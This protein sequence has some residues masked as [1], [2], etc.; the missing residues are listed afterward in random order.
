MKKRY[1]SLDILRGLTVALMIVVN[2]PG[3]WGK[4]FPP[5]R[6]AEWDGCTPTDLVFPFFLF[7]VGTSMAFA[8]AKYD[9]LSRE[10]LTKIF[11]RGIGIFLVGLGLHAFPFYPTWQDPDLTLWQNYLEWFREFRTFGVLQ[12]IALCYVVASVLALW[13]RIP[14]KILA[15]IAVLSVL[16][17]G[18][19]LV[20]AGPEGAF[21]LEG[22]ITR[23]IDAA[24]I[25]EAH[26]YNG[27]RFA[28][29]SAAAFDPEGIFGVLTGSCT[30]LLGFLIGNILRRDG[31]SGLKIA[32]LYSL[33]ALSL[34]F[35]QILSIWIPINKPLW[36]VSYVFYAG[37]WAIFVLALLTWMTEV[38][39]W[40]KVF[41]PLRAFG[42]NPLFIFSLSSLLAKTISSVLGWNV[43]AVFGATEFLSLTYALLYMLLHLFV[44]MVLYKKNIV[45]K[46]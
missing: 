36:S 9:G 45:I 25:G 21:T 16:H 35:S 19:Q 2:N 5:L 24:L 10:A 28:D 23:H 37:G 42:M 22:N 29:G 43:A 41:T 30:A 6:H 15:S 46:I 39:G 40:V 7:C 1:L 12:R 14:K 20:F 8:L 18:I 32:H 13:L 27:Y 26:L 33:A 44:A 38:K 11:K 17:V 34:A 31:D 3:S 4:M